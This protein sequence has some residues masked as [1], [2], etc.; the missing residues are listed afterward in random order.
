MTFVLSQGV[1]EEVG[2]ADSRESQSHNDVV[3]HAKDLVQQM[4]D[5]PFLL[6]LTKECDVEHARA[7]LALHQG[8]AITIHINRYD[9]KIECKYSIRRTVTLLAL[10]LQP[11]WYCKVRL[12]ST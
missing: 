9:G 2:M 4:L 1:G 3:E 8:K 7:K 11:W 10:V 6:D 5:D 12:C